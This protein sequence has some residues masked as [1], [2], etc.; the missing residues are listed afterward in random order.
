MADINGRYTQRDVDDAYE[1]W[2]RAARN[3]PKGGNAVTE[4]LW[5]AY[6]RIDDAFLA[7]QD[8]NR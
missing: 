1:A 8:V 2:Q 7:Q 4:A 3:A 5:K 6:C